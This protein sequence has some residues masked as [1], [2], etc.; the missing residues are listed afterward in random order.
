MQIQLLTAKRLEKCVGITVS[1]L[2]LIGMGVIAGGLEE[3]GK[4]ISIKTFIITVLALRE[5]L[6]GWINSNDC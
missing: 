4:G 6:L 3:V 1:F 2:I 5:A